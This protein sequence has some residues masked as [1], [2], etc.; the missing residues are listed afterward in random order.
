KPPNVVYG[1]AWIIFGMFIVHVF[2]W[3]SITTPLVRINRKGLHIL[4]RTPRGETQGRHI[5][6]DAI[7]NVRIENV[8]VDGPSIRKGLLWVVVETDDGSH[9]IGQGLNKDALEW[10]KDC[11]LSKVAYSRPARE[12][13]DE[14]KLDI[15]FDPTVPVALKLNTCGDQ[16]EVAICNPKMP[17][18][19]CGMMIIFAIPALFI[20]IG[21]WFA[22]VGA[23]IGTFFMGGLIWAFIT[24]PLVRI[25]RKGLHILRRTPWGETQG[26]HIRADA[27]RNVRVSKGSAVVVE[28][29]DGNHDIGEGL[30]KDTLEWLKNCILNKIA[31]E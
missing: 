16:L 26:T 5:R 30:D 2:I 31:T 27:I 10:L 25:N 9:T 28:T 3:P 4:R 18:L 29:D 22:I 14:G 11:I 8:R 12:L 6:A 20:W 24:T 19:G 7:E 13:A 15:T 21:G 1:I 23:L 17:L